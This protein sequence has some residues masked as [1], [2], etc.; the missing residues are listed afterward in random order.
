VKRGEPLPEPGCNKPGASKLEE[1]AEVVRNHEGG[2]RC[3]DQRWSRP[4]AA[5]DSSDVAGVDSIGE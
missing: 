2:T 5:A 4:E 3:R 1:T